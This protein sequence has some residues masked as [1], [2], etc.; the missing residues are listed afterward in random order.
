[1]SHIANH[2]LFEGKHKVCFRNPRGKLT[3]EAAVP[4]SGHAA[5]KQVF[6]DGKPYAD[7]M[8]DAGR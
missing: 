3:V 1:L 4:R 6:V 2:T 5:I 8:K 7:A